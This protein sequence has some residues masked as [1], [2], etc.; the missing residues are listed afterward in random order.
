MANT[1]EDVKNI[2][3][4]GGEAVIDP[5]NAP[6]EWG[7]LKLQNTSDNGLVL[8]GKATIGGKEQD[9]TILV[10]FSNGQATLT[11]P[12]GG[13]PM[14]DFVNGL[15]GLVRQDLGPVDKTIVD[16]T[17]A[18][19]ILP[20]SRPAVTPTAPPSNSAPAAPPPTHDPAP[21]PA[22]QPAPAAKTPPAAAVTPGSGTAP[23][24]GTSPTPQQNAGGSGVLDTAWQGIKAGAD[25]VKQDAADAAIRKAQEE[26]GKMAM[27]ALGKG[28]SVED[29]FDKG[30]DIAIGVD[31]ALNPDT[32]P[33]SN[34]PNPSPESPPPKS[35]PP[36]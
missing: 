2:L 20:G 7:G 19:H 31:K 30:V 35:A 1:R 36:R 32:G 13:K 29:V 18:I 8:T 26:G 17:G 10:S 23:A 14:A 25:R 12:T 24:T 21:T 27:D 28:Q 33:P 5:V 9:V 11:P 15:E 4:R 6:P 22:T 34:P 3:N 16:R